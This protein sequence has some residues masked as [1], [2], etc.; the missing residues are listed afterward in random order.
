MY[1]QSLLVAHVSVYQECL[2]YKQYY[3]QFNDLWKLRLAM[4]TNVHVNKHSSLV[5]YSCA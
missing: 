2:I 3:F 5:I 4:L 1:W